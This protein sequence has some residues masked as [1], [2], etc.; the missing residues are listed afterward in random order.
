MI[1]VYNSWKIM[2][3]DTRRKNI[4]QPSIRRVLNLIQEFLKIWKRSNK[5]GKWKTAELD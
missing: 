5:N 2:E 3:L 1:K 4:K